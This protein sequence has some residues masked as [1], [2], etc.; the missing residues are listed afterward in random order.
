MAHK[1]VELGVYSF[2]DT[3]RDASGHQT[4]T[5]QAI[6][7]MLEAVHVAE[8]AGL[9][10][11]GFGE[12]HTRS[13]PLSSPTALINAAAASTNRIRL[14]TAVTVLSTDDPVRVYQQLATAAAIAPG[15][16]ELVSGLA[17][18]AGTF[19]RFDFDEQA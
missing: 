9:N 3:P 19:P 14:G 7:N 15:R 4:T 8:Q 2:G 5:A 18:S 10:F 11:F 12:H 17:S 1:T 16:V 6:R 13:Q